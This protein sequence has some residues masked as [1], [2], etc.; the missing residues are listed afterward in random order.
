MIAYL[1]V[2]FSYKNY[3][4]V[5]SAASTASELIGKLKTPSVVPVSGVLSW[6]QNKDTEYPKQERDVYQ[7]SKPLV[8][9]CGILIVVRLPGWEYSDIVQQETAYAHYLQK[10]IEYL[11]P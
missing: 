11:N 9:A 8:D 10:P 4:S 2:P 3:D 1:S 6:Y 7:F 5:T